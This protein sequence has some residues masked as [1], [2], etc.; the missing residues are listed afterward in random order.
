MSSGIQRRPFTP[1]PLRLRQVLAGGSVLLLIP[2]ALHAATQ[3]TGLTDSA[4]ARAVDVVYIDD[5][6]WSM[7]GRAHNT[8]DRQQLDSLVRAV[9]ACGEGGML[10]TV[11]GARPEQRMAALPLAARPV[12][13]PL[14]VRVEDTAHNPFGARDAQRAQNRADSLVKVE[15]Q[16]FDHG[17]ASARQ[18]F[19]SHVTSILAT[20]FD[21]ARGSAVCQA[22]RDARDFFARP[23]S[24]TSTRVMRLLVLN[25]DMDATDSGTRCPATNIADVVLAWSDR[26]PVGVVVVPEPVRVFTLK[27]IIT[28]LG[29]GGDR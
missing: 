1:L 23:R 6:S 21:S 17:A 26:S 9:P 13:T 16:G 24:R 27:D 18:N 22:L 15:Q 11:V 19:V 25:T 28:L 14:R 3:R 8:V 7:R 5:I 4:C 12:G 29:G 2:A 20:P 10:V